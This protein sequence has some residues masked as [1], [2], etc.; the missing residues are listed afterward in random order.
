MGVVPAHRVDQCQWHLGNEPGDRGGVD[1]H[2]AFGLD[3]P[4][5]NA[6]GTQPSESQGVLEQEDA[7]H[8]A[9]GSQPSEMPVPVQ[10]VP[11][12]HFQSAT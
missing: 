3:P 2:P 4:E 1:G 7:E 12:D 8:V 11:E 6:T 10:Q 9:S 5:L